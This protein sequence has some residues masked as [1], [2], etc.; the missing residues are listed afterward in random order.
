MCCDEME[1]WW[2]IYTAVNI[3]IIGSRD[4]SLPVAGP[5]IT[6]TNAPCRKLDRSKKHK[7]MSIQ[8]IRITNTCVEDI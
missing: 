6:L 7:F 3:V 1:E 8:Y 4:G 2:L 5:S